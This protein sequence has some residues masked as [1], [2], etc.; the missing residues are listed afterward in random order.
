MKLSAIQREAFEYIATASCFAVWYAEYIIAV[1]VKSNNGNKGYYI[2][3][4]K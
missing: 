1:E 3:V 2:E 4:E